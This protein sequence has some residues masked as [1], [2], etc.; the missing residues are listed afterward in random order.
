MVTVGE[1]CE[2]IE[3]IAPLC[4][5]E[6]YDNAGLTYGQK[7]MEVTGVLC[8][9]DVT[10]DVVEEAIRK[11]CNMIVSHHPLIFRGVKQLTGVD[12]VSRTL[13][14]AIK[15]EIAL[16]AAHTNL[17]KAQEGVSWKLAKILGLEKITLLENDGDNGG[18]CGLGVIGEWRMAKETKDA[19][20]DVKRVT[21]SSNLRYVG[22]KKMVKRIAICTGSGSDLIEQARRKGADL[23]LTSD[24]KYHE[25]QDSEGEMIVVSA[26]HYETE[27][28][29]KELLK[30][31]IKKKIPTFA[32]YKSEI[33]TNPIKHI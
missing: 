21:G 26:G 6:D 2:I 27:Q 9:L 17:D 3:E 13:I 33:N 31:E 24:V 8:T 10:E 29:T 30:E 22:N 5:Q 20:Q 25:M 7:G 14:M 23:F 32:V 28:H 4:W 18:V 1:I 15:H 19:L 16:Y 12:R 11:G